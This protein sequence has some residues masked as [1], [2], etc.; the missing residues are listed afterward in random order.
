MEQGIK[1]RCGTNLPERRRNLIL[2]RLCSLP[3]GLVEI[4]SVSSQDLEQRSSLLS[5]AVAVHDTGFVHFLESAHAR[6]HQSGHDLSF[7]DDAQLDGFVPY[8]FLRGGSLPP[9]PHVESEVAFYATDASTPIHADT[10]DV[11][12]RDLAVVSAA[13]DAICAGQRCAYSLTT[14]P[15]HHAAP[16][17]YGGYCFLNYAALAARRLHEAGHRVALLDVDYHAGDGT[18]EC[19]RDF[20]SAFFSIHSGRDYPYVDFGEHG[21]ELPRGTAWPRYAEALRRA[22]SACADASAT[23]LVVSLGLDT[24]AGDPDASDNAGF[25]LQVAD[26]AEMGRMLAGVGL[27]VLVLQEGGYRMDA[28]AE[29]VAQFMAGLQRRAQL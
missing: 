3:P 6:W 7:C 5:G 4:S 15:G 28:V 25:E 27:P 19:V 26:F 16:Q 9:G 8:H 29:A 23:V 1:Q 21:I 13:V 22:L 17:H 18:L 14:H 12:A 10:A 11:L 20:C 24:L 2:A